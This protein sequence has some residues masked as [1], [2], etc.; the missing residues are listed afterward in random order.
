MATV[1][2][3]EAA[4]MKA[5]AAGDEAAAREI[6][7][8]IKRVRTVQSAPKKRV[9]PPRT[10][11]SGIAPVNA[12]L[13]NIN[14]ILI[15]VPEGAYNLAAMVTD[16]ISRMVFGKEA[17]KQAQGQRRAATD[18][19]SRNLVT[20]P[21]PLARSL[22][23]SMAPAAAVTRT[24]NVL[25]PLAPK[26]PVI[27]DT[28][29]KVLAST[30]TG[31]V[32]VKGASIPETIAL[33][34]AGGGTSGATTAALMGEN[35]VEGGLYGAG[36]P[37]VGTI[38]KKLGGR[39][40][41]IFRMSK[42][43]AGKI[44]REALGKDVDAARAAFAQLSPDDQRLAQQVLIEAGVEPSPFIALGNIAG[45]QMDPDTTRII[46][47]QQKAARDA[48]LAA[49]SGGADPTAQRAAVEAERR[50]VN[51]TTGPAREAALGD[52]KKTNA[53][54]AETE[55]LTSDLQRRADEQSGLARRMTLGAERAETRLNQMDDFGNVFDPA[56]VA[57]ER[58]I[59]GAM[60][61]R[62]ETAAQNAIDLRRQAREAKLP[63][64]SRIIADIFSDFAPENP[65]PLLASPLVATLRQ[66]ASAEGIRTS[67]ARRALLKLANQIEG[68]AD[69]NGMLN[70]YDL[71]TVRKEASD[72][73]EKYVASS[74]QPS[75]GSKKRA[76]GLV[77]GFKN[78][79]DKALGPKFQDYLVQHQLGMQKVNMQELAA[80]GAQLAEE[81]PDEFIALMNRRRPKV[82]E[83]VYG[84]GTNQFDISGLALAD[85]ERY[86]A[87]KSSAK[88]LETLNRMNELTSSG[89]ARAQNIL[90]A[91]EPGKLSRAAMSVIR[92]KYPP[93][94]FLGTG[95]QGATSAFVTPAVQKEIAKA[96]E[97]GAN[98]RAAMDVLPTA[99]HMSNEVQQRLSPTA[100]NIMA[101]QFG[102]PSTLGAEYNFPDIDP[103]SG[104]PL[105]DVDFS[106]GYAVPIY[107][108]IPRDKRFKNL[109][110][111]RR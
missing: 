45:K 50:A 41:D 15:G 23:Q 14:E 1:A 31:G 93:L 100:R 40:V 94:A 21:R 3:L 20:Q 34:V 107:G 44:I 19:L 82:V 8:E 85:P 7:A 25:A 12:F 92:A 2:Q 89:Q 13:D 105:V 79:V 4:L 63:R 60:T 11:G 53:A 58:G 28:V 69:Q 62:G 101:Q 96:Y 17:V 103:E 99:V 78:A 73:V 29:S 75:T 80:R 49:I 54:V 84:K 52:I 46:L 35:P 57:R 81:S 47:E 106:E 42:V 59:A 30:A 37:I 64:G 61:Q 71:Y 5:D 56:A 65:E 36:L 76:A 98:M 32:G 70:P 27:G 102:A 108:N 38:L 104:E 86:L 111:M 51:E 22:G 74:A 95:T 39:A 88:E 97:S 72:I 55:R 43:E 90:S 109:N 9:A 87:L 68:A 24:A 18:Y 48:R 66:Q 16:P 26:I 67:S 6:A 77:I 10:R 83:D 91:Q 33:K 110:A